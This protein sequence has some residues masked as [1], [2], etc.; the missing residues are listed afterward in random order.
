MLEKI[1]NYFGYYKIPRYYIYKIHNDGR[2]DNVKFYANG[3]SIVFDHFEMLTFTSVLDKMN[4]KYRLEKI[5]IPS[6]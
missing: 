5:T 1:M 2:D 6:G 3:R 4:R